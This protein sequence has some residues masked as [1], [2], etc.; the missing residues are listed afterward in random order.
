[1][2]LEVVDSGI[3]MTEEQIAGLFK[4]FSQVD[5][6]TTRKHGGTGLG[7]AISKRLA[8]KL[9]GDIS[10]ASAAGEGSTFTVTVATGPLDGVKLIDKPTEAQFPIDSD[11]KPAASR[12]QLD[13]RVLLAEDGPDHQRLIAFLL[14]K[15]GAEV[16]VADN[17]QIACD[18][19]LAARD[20][21]ASFDVI[22]MDMQMPVMGGYEATGKLR[23][24]GHTGPI[25]AL[26]AH[27]MSTDRAKC[28]DAGCDDYATKPID[29]KKLVSMVAEYASRQ[30]LHKV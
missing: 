13:C 14:K 19:A 11:A 5:S 16:V 1:M 26:T 12:A 22:L 21:R 8:E 24:A 29:H 4:P 30:E 25:I 28:L 15:A 3:G 6:S 2:Q 10:V 27:A 23:E 18:L 20:E 17:G 9:G 7:L